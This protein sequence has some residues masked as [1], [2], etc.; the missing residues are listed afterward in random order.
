MD[1]TRPL[2]GD[3]LATSEGDLWRQQR[4]ALQPTFSQASVADMAG[5]VGAVVEEHLDGWQ[6]DAASGVPIDLTVRLERLVQDVIVRTL[7]R[8]DLRDESET[9]RHAFS[10]AQDYINFRAWFPFA[11]P[12]A[13]PTPR[14]LRF[15]RALA[16]VDRSIYRMIDERGAENAAAHRAGE[17][18]A[19]PRDLMSAVL[20][21]AAQRQAQAGGND[22]DAL[23]RQ[24]RD[25]L[26]TLLFAGYETTAGALTWLF[27][28][29]RKHAQIAGD[30]AKEVQ[31]WVGSKRF[32]AGDVDR[33]ELTRRVVRETLRLYPP[34]WVLVR[35]SRE[36]DVVDGY[37]L[38]AGATVLLSPYVTQR[39]ERYWPDPERFDPERFTASAEA[40]RPRG[41]Y[42]PYASGPRQCIGIHVANLTLE[43][44][45]AAVLRRWSLEVDPALQIVP[46]PRTTL[47]PSRSLMAILRPR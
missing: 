22:T 11:L 46:Q 20:S 4:R 18:A 3:G 10:L 23:R 15:R 33:L 40:E 14:N 39:L 6:R 8:A 47:R 29:L 27:Y 5:D 13:V 12:V 7:F 44:T 28:A 31:T 42:F 41:V 32:Q 17:G 45:L 19:V 16:A 21:A 35:T 37:D 38:P 25:E 43:I 2:L 26:V 24:L 34:G 9:F 30:V 1:V 36:R